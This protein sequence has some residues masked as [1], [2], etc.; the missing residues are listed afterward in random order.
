MV[1]GEVLPDDMYTLLMTDIQLR[2][3]LALRLIDLFGGHIYHVI[4]VLR[5][6]KN[7]KH[8]DLVPREVFPEGGFGNVESCL[9]DCQDDEETKR[10]VEV[11]K[12]LATKGFVPMKGGDKIGRILTRNNVA[13]FV[14]PTSSTYGINKA[15][16]GGMVPSTQTCRLDIVRVLS[17]E[18]LI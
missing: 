5:R 14:S 4:E 10:M 3:N 8:Q 9:S 1:L 18:N 7:S 15:F 17:G 16:K 2:H 11:L 13:G 6:L 12:I